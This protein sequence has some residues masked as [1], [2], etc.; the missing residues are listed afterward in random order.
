VFNFF[1]PGY[2]PSGEIANGGLVAP[3]LQIAS[4]YQ[5]TLVTNLFYQQAFQRHSAIPGLP[6]NAVVIDI[7]AELALAADSEA[8]VNR[9]V[10]KL[11][12]GQVS[13]TLKAE[14]KAAVERVPASSAAQRVSEA[15]YLIVTSPEYALQR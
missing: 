15:I 4:E 1:S 5:N 14:A 11:L 10:A 13:A 3:E 6:D 2:A 8:L 9:V 7:S 12:A